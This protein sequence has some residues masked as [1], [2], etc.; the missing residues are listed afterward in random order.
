MFLKTSPRGATMKSGDFA[1]SPRGATV[2]SGDLTPSPA[3]DVTR[4]SDLPVIHRGGAP[5]VDAPPLCMF[6]V[7]AR[8]AVTRRG[9]A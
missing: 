3:G 2:K 1:P 8:L 4:D 5:S 7:H 9:H 6:T